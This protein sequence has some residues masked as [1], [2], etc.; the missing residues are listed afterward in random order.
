M[1]SLSWFIYLADVLPSLAKFFQ[2]SL[3]LTSLVGVLLFAIYIV[4]KTDSRS[5][6]PERNEFYVVKGLH[7]YRHMTFICLFI[8]GLLCFVPSQKTFYTI[9]TAEIAQKSIEDVSKMPEM[10]KIRKLL[11]THLDKLLKEDN[12][13]TN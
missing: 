3:V 8:V 6:D 12:E 11:N 10:S 4:N 9:A 13:T 7:P 5:E 2:V 1:S